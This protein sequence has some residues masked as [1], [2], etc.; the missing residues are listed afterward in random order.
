M[1]YRPGGR[2]EKARYQY[3]YLTLQQYLTMKCQKKEPADFFRKNE[4]KR[5]AIYGA[6]ELGKCLIHDLIGTDIQIEYIIDMAYKQ[7]PNGYKGIPVVGLDEMKA[8]EEVDAVVITVL[9]E[10]NSI[11]DTLLEKGVS[12]EKILNI[13]DVVYSLED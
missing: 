7:Y 12:L 11:M 4:L 9:F 8:C 5:V 1:Y 6:G 3:S 13:N 10:M 2:D